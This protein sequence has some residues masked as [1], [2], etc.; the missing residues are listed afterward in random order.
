V[1]VDVQ[2]ILVGRYGQADV[3]GAIITGPRSHETGESGK[4][5]YPQ[6]PT[7]S[8]APTVE[9]G[10]L[11]RLRQ[12]SGHKRSSICSTV[13]FVKGTRLFPSPVAAGPRAAAARR[14]RAIAAPAVADRAAMA[15]PDRSRPTIVLASTSRYRAG[16]LRRIGLDFMQRDPRVDER[17]RPGEHPRAHALRLAASKARAVAAD[18]A[19]AL[20]IGSDQVAARDGVVIGKPGSDQ[21]AV[22][23]LTAC[24]GRNVEFFTA[25][26][27]LRSADAFERSHVDRTTVKFRELTA[28]EIGRYVEKD[29]PLDCAGA[30]KAEGLGITLFREIRSTDPTALIGMPLIWLAAALREGGAQ[31]P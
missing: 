31:L 20:V 25:V 10:D 23:Q 7:E 30:F 21:L 4:I 15:R 19:H 5:R 24:S 26:Y 29:Q 14:T 2:A 12:G 11:Q 8:S 27:V 17:T 6:A 3:N 1:P 18:F 28:S 13:F 16:L 22:A 9:L